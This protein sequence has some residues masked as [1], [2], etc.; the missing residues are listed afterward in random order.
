MNELAFKHAGFA[1]SNGTVMMGDP[2]TEILN[3]INEVMFRAG[4][5]AGW[6][7][8]THGLDDGLT[9]SQSVKANQTLVVNV[10]TSDIRWFAGA[11]AIQVVA[12]L[13]ILPVFYGEQLHSR[14]LHL[15]QHAS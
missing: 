8:L 6:D 5:V 4:V 10:Y 14:P 2:T 11:A 9:A 15:T 7:N 3:I 12:L 1:N 13:L